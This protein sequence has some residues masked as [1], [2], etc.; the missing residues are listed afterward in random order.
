MSLQHISLHDI[1]EKD[2]RLLVENATAE[3]KA[4]EYKEILPN[5]S[6]SEKKEFLADVSSF[7]NALGGDLVYG[8]RAVSGLPTEVCG[9]GSIDNDAAI[10]RLENLIRD[11]IAPRIPGIVTQVVPTPSNGGNALVLRIP[12][13]WLAPHMVTFQNYSRFYSRNSN[14]KYPLDVTEIRSAFLASDSIEKRIR[15]FRAARLTGIIAGET[16]IPI[17]ERSL[18]VCHVVPFSANLP[19][20]NIDF[21]PIIDPA[22]LSNVYR[23]ITYMGYRHNFDGLLAHGYPHNSD[24][25]YSYVQ[26]YRNGSVEVVDCV[27]GIQSEYIDILKLEQILFSSLPNIVKALSKLNVQIPLAIMVTLIGV[28]GRTVLA[29]NMHN[30]MIEDNLYPIERDTLVLPEAILDSLDTPV[31][32]VLRPALDIIWNA[33]GWYKSNKLRS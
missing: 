8:I 24:V 13:S 2:L 25:A 10:L 5:N 31:E 28:K 7:A 15:D 21:T 23:A 22:L 6:D 4:I 33:G 29:Q 16:P 20:Q 32:E 12:R 27:A 18:L 3:S 14:G 17:A 9:L 30:S 11:G 26:F 1:N 19:G